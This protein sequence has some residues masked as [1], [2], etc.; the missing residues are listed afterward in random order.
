MKIYVPEESIKL[1]TS[2]FP[3]FYNI[4]ILHLSTIQRMKEIKKKRIFFFLIENKN[5]FSFERTAGVRQGT[6][7]AVLSF[8]C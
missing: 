6:A 2:T 7:G 3:P 1:L 8:A 5:L 4:L